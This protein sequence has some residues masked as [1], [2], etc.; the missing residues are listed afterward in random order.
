MRHVGQVKRLAVLGLYILV[1]FLAS[2]TALGVWFPPLTS[3]GLWF[4]AGLA[5][6]ILSNLL[7]TPFYHKP[8]DTISYGV[9]ALIAMLSVRSALSPATTDAWLWK[10][11]VVY[12][13]ALLSA[14][15]LSIVLKDSKRSVPHK[16]SQSAYRFTEQFGGAKYIFSPIFLFALVAFHRESGTE[17]LIIGASWA[18]IVS[19]SPAE[20]LIALIA[21]IREIWSISGHQKPF[22]RI[23]GHSVP[24][25]VLVGH[26]RTDAVSFGDIL[27]VPGQD[28][29][30][31]LGLALDHV[32]IAEDRW[33]RVAQLD[34]PP[35]IRNRLDS[36]AS[37]FDQCAVPPSELVTELRAKSDQPLLQESDKVVGIVA[38]DTDLTR[39]RIDVMRTEIRLEEGQLLRVQIQNKPV[40]Y[41]IINGLTREEI[42]Q[43]KN[44]RGYVRAEAKKIGHWNPNEDIFEPVEWLP[45]PNSPVFLV[46][47][48]SATAKREAIGHFPDTAFAVSINVDD[49][50]THNGAILGILG[51]GK[52]YLSLELVERIMTAGIKTL[53]LDLTNEYAKHLTDYYEA[54][55]MQSLLDD[56]E[57]IS[58]PEG[59]TKVSKHVEEGGSINEFTQTIR[60]QIHDFLDS[61]KASL[62][63]YNP[64]KFEIWRQDSKPYK[65]KAS[66]ASLTAPEITRI[67]TEAA[68][69]ALQE[70]GMTEKARC[71]LVYEEAHSLVPEWSSV[72]SEGDKSAT[73]GTAR[74]ILQGRKYGLGCLLVTQRTANVTKTILNQ[75]N[76]V[77][78]MRSF[79]ATGMEFLS[80]YIGEDYAGV[81]SKLEDRHAIVFGRGSSCKD[82]VLIRLNDRSDFQ[83]VFHSEDVKR[84]EQ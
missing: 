47:A 83:A 79:D 36:S 24:G 34:T 62:R 69:E 41:Q 57:A 4:Y 73:N 16:I 67:V 63:I 25:I 44:K 38:P 23:V 75:C 72:A 55:K 45:N 80:N 21:R 12:L 54:E 29:K 76:T 14:A 59:K 53:C 39:L 1:L 28:G 46:T 60:E 11:I 6:L 77:F 42:L 35:A 50:V 22:G 40:F 17:V 66:M 56:L 19:L 13:L 27:T 9:T 58:G 26:D 20:K 15:M 37:G 48:E 78:A 2:L 49:L 65:G 84:E 5:M 10:L 70:Q 3:K 61:S 18:L 71:C 7:V 33:L 74:A 43:K 31:N 81:L 68:L 82:P 8:A 30:P 52:T 64:A 32:G 51:V